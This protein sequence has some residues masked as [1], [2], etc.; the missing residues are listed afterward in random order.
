MDIVKSIV[1]G[2]IKGIK[3]I[4]RGIFGDKVEINV[5]FTVKDIVEDIIVEDI[6]EDIV[7]EDI[8]VEGIMKDIVTVIVEDVV[9][10]IKIIK[11]FKLK[12]IKAGFELEVENFGRFY[13]S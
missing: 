10:N 4:T 2:F 13:F 7:V 6:V 8:V 1:N 5:R 3:N 12:L 11:D 9:M